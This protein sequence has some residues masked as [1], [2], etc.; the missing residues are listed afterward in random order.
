MIKRSFGQDNV[1]QVDETAGIHRWLFRRISCVVW[2]L[3]SAAAG[4][5]ADRRC[6]TFP[7]D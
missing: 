6:G 4:K 2:Y 7:L 1:G 5:E 3:Q